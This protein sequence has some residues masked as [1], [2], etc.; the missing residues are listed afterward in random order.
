M[1]KQ[2]VGLGGGLLV[3]VPVPADAEFEASEA[4]MAVQA[5]LA[6][7]DA[8]GV[9]GKDVTPFV[10]ASVAHRTEGRSVQANLALLRNNARVAARIAVS[11]SRA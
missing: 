4:E 2:E 3:A 7:A 8:Q 9:T 6:E 1:A 10:L 11:L 5:A